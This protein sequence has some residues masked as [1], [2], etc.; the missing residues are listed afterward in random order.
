MDLIVTVLTLL[1]YIVIIAIVFYAIVYVLGLIGIVV[2]PRIMQLLMVAFGLI[3]LIWL[4]TALL[5]GGG[6]A[7]PTLKMG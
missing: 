4:V 7:L 6:V 2:P 3:V 5:G 1:L